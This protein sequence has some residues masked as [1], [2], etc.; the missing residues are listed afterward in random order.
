M[1]KLVLVVCI[2]VASVC[3]SKAREC[4]SELFYGKP[5]EKQCCGKKDVMS[6]RDSC[7]NVECSS[8]Y[9]CG[10]SCCKHHRC[11][12]TYCEEYEAD[13]TIIIICVSIASV[14]FIGIVI[15]VVLQLVYRRRRA[16]GA[17]IMVNAA[18]NQTQI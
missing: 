1:N 14:V 15:L 16:S 2:L 8:N 5:C 10:N 13:V 3:V 11:G 6:C 17:V 4:Q 18:E 7:E 9:D 12:A